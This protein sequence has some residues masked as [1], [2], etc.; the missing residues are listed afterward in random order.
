MTTGE[1]RCLF[2]APFD[3]LGDSLR[4]EYARWIPT[5]FREVWRVDDLTANQGVTAWVP[6]PGQHFVIDARVL[7]LFPKLQVVVTPSTGR[8]HIDREACSRRG[9]AVY[10]LLDDRETLESISASAEFSFLLLLNA[11]RRLD[12]GLQ[13]VSSGRWRAREEELRGY[14]L[15]G[16]QVGVVGLGRIGRRLARYCG[17]F[18][19]QVAYHDP[20]VTDPVL[21]A[22]PLEQVFA[23]A[24]IVCVCCSLT[25][26][27]TNLVNGGLLRRLRPNAVL[28]NTARGEVI[29]EHDLAAVLRERGDIRVAL[30]VLAGE[31]S[32][33]H[34]TS[35][36]MPFYESGRIVITPHMAGVTR[37]SQT[38]AARGAL[39]LL[40]RHLGVV[41]A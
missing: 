32:D 15:A 14:E 3:F 38:K 16:K 23:E 30:D 25:P 27:T 37:E 18:D 22:W 19:A 34:L 17:A 29:A 6:N 4:G 11:L 21:P 10:S 40:H 39:R 9:V 2:S 20:F 8:N 24:D 35:P 41:A 12:I 33:T 7:A 31:V 26:D 1:H 36:L 5:E 13:A 28:V